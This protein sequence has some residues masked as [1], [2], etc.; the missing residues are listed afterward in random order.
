[1]DTSV[2]RSEEIE[3]QAT[4]WLVKLDAGRSPDVMAQHAAW[5]AESA[6][7]EVAYA[8]LSLAWKRMDALRR[9]RPLDP[10]GE[11]DP[12][13]LKPKKKWWPRG[14]GTGLGALRRSEGNDSMNRSKLFAGAAIGIALAATVA[15]SAFML[16][17]PEND[18]VL[19][20]RVGEQKHVMLA[21]GS[22]ADLNTNTRIRVHYTAA[23]RQI[24]LERG[25]IMISV[26]HDASRPLDVVANGVLTRAVGTKFNVRLHDDSH[27][28]T[29]LKEGRVL[30]LRRDTVLGIPMAP[31]PVGH[32][33][34]AGERAV[35]DARN[36]AID[37]LTPSEMEQLL[38]WTSGR[39]TFQQ[40]KLS[41][42]VREMNRYNVRHLKILDPAVADTRVG[43]GFDT[44]H[45]EA[46]A[47][48]LTGFFGA[49]ALKSEAAAAS[50]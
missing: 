39:I 42:V 18:L 37:K 45:A 27:V 28:E 43:G 34:V 10:P 46:Y 7:H 11:A 30:I 29:L 3:A 20:T 23:H 2:N 1:M 24:F 9:M 21:D 13:L 15:A 31:R 4:Q 8:K 32:T 36:A 16:L 49:S 48:D 17:Q 12:D 25:E 40:E 41:T 5:I 26:A 44:A 38:Q 33:L 14:T 35:V 19:A 22:V 47:E 6:R 50:E